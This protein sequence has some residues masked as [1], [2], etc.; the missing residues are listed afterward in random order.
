MTLRYRLAVGE[1]RIELDTGDSDDQVPGPV[2]FLMSPSAPAAVF[3]SY[4]LGE[5]AEHLINAGAE[6][7]LDKPIR[8]ICAKVRCCSRA[9]RRCSACA[10]SL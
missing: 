8:C 4:L 10:A 7:L 9:S 1:D 6:Q 2:N 5:S 3:A